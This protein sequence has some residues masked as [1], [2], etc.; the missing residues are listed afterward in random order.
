MGNNVVNVEVPPMERGAGWNIVG[1]C[2]SVR[3]VNECGQGE[4]FLFEWIGSWEVGAWDGGWNRREV[5]VG[6]SLKRLGHF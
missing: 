6:G 2:V 3:G 5:H 1:R 4:D